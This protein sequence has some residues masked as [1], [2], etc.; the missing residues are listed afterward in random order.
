M[1]A[2][3]RPAGSVDMATALS[4]YNGP[5]NQRLAA[6]LLRRAGFGGTPDEIARLARMNIGEA[7][8]SLIHFPS[9]ANWPQPDNVFDPYSGG[10]LP[11]ARGRAGAMMTDQTTRR[12]LQ[13]ELRRKARESIISLQQWWLQR[14]LTTPAPLQEK[15]T[16]YYH[17]HFTSTAI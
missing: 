8:E 12:Q 9:T 3:N 7:V 15:M 4:P 11:L 14:M 13:M 5:W 6:H 2:S 16:F 10:F 1:A 17:G